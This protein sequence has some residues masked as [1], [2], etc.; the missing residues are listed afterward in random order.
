MNA[1]ATIAKATKTIN[2]KLSAA[3]TIKAKAEARFNLVANAMAK[4]DHRLFSS[5]KLSMAAVDTLATQITVPSG[6]TVDALSKLFDDLESLDDHLRTLVTIFDD[7][8]FNRL[9]LFGKSTTFANNLSYERESALGAYRRMDT[10]YSAL[11]DD[12]INAMDIPANVNRTYERIV[13]DQRTPNKFTIKV[14]DALVKLSGPKNNLFAI[15]EKQKDVLLGATRKDISAHAGIQGMLVRYGL[16]PV[17]P[18]V[19]IDELF[20]I[21]GLGDPP[22]S[23]AFMELAERTGACVV[24]VN[25][26]STSPVEFDLRG[27]I[28][29]RYILANGL[30]T[31]QTAGLNKKVLRK[32][33]TSALLPC[34]DGPGRAHIY[35]PRESRK[36][37]IFETINGR[38]YRALGKNGEFPVSAESVA[39]L[40]S[41]LTTRCERYSEIQLGIIKGAC[42]SSR[43][44][45]LLA[46]YASAR[47]PEISSEFV[48][49]AIIE[50][51]SAVFGALLFTLPANAGQLRRLS[52]AR[53]VIS[54]AV[55]S[56]VTGSSRSRL[57]N[58]QEHMLTFVAKYDGLIDRFAKELDRRWST[59]TVRDGIFTEYS[60][61]KLRAELVSLY[62]TVLSAAV[63]EMDK[64]RAW[65]EH[66][67]TL[68]EFVLD[69]I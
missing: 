58:S 44:D 57:G 4:L 27:I 65:T 42:F 26:G 8:E 52:P 3:R 15:I 20:D 36:V 56:A 62:K 16:T 54:A 9:A 69:S 59:V 22:Q 18:S 50:D 6:L 10:T 63:D 38:L 61:E 24:V 51:L 29:Q 12:F 32:Y 45:T 47:S 17:F 5:M 11:I 46:K 66:D 53:D 60:E 39:G 2:E 68:K 30:D 14:I 43:A 7:S 21:L 49:K 31:K 55:I 41:G 1:A 67:I 48:R 35:G 34:A 23:N 33:A 13:S 19:A 25:K 28:D 40:L 37:Y 64:S